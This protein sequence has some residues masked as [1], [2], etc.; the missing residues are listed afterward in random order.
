MEDNNI[1]LIVCKS[2]IEEIHGKTWRN[3]YLNKSFQSNGYTSVRPYFI[4]YVSYD[5]YPHCDKIHSMIVNVTPAQI[6]NKKLEL[7]ID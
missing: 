7:L 6:R 3:F 4:C 1:L 2:I 5:D